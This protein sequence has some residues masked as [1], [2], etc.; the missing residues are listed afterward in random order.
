MEL[1]RPAEST[2]SD[3]EDDCS[4]DDDEDFI[5]QKFTFHDLD[6]Q[7]REC[8]RSYGA[9]FPKLN[10]SSPKVRAPSLYWVVILLD[11]LVSLVGRLLDSTRFFPSQVYFPLR[12]LPPSEIF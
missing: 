6:G 3:D 5:R 10:F 4:T 11:K 8:I 2:L 9:V 12:C 1:D 7:I